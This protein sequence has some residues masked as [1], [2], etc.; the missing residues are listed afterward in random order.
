MGG[1]R[2]RAEGDW[3]NSYPVSDRDLQLSG[4]LTMN[5]AMKCIMRRCTNVSVSS[6]QDAKEALSKA[7]R[8]LHICERLAV[9]IKVLIFCD[10]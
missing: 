8:V 10:S 1:G 3:K 2:Y 4:F 6:Q 7:V 5:S 9:P